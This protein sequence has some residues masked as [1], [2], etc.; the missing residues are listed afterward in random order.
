MCV[1][2][3]SLDGGA[4]QPLVDLNKNRGKGKGLRCQAFQPGTYGFLVL[5]DKVKVWSV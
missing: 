1:L 3:V 5:Q 4:V 2:V